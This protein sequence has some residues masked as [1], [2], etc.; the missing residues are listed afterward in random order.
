MKTIIKTITYKTTNR[1]VRIKV[2]NDGRIWD[3]NGRQQKMIKVA[4]KGYL[5]T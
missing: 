3:M 2:S 4:Y 5:A 1:S